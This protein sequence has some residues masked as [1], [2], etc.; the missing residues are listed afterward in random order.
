MSF[1]GDIEFGDNI[2]LQGEVVVFAVIKI[3][4]VQSDR[5]IGSNVAVKA[6]FPV[7]REVLYACDPLLLDISTGRTEA[8]HHGCQLPK[9]R[10]RDRQLLRKGHVLSAGLANGQGDFS[11]P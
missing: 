7:T 6:N 10:K 1:V 9:A 11:R 2:S 5:K 8:F 4:P 3:V